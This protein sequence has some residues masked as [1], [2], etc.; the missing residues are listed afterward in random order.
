MGG[1]GG[2]AVD[3]RFKC[4]SFISCCR[5]TVDMLYLR[6]HLARVEFRW[7]SS[8][9]CCVVQVE[10]KPVGTFLKSDAITKHN[11]EEV[12]A[13]CYLKFLAGA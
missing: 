6:L 2:L 12:Q 10:E 5:N 8:C 3:E 13:L 4:G 11:A 7:K 9:D 1:Q